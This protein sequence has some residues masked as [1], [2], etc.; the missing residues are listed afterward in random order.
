MSP[1]SWTEEATIAFYESGSQY[2]LDVS[3]EDW[4]AQWLARR[5]RDV[6]GVASSSSEQTHS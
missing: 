1:Q 4:E 5:G 2:E 6:E 3:Q